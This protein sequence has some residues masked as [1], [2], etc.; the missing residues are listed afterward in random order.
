MICQLYS[1]NSHRISEKIFLTLLLSFI[2][3]IASSQ[4]ST[5]DFTCGI[6][7][8]I[9]NFKNSQPTAYSQ[10]LL[11]Y[12]SLLE[13][14]SKKAREMNQWK[15]NT[16]PCPF[17]ITVIP[18]AFQLFHNNEAI[19]VGHN[20]SLTQLQ[21]VVEQLN[22]DFS[23]Y[24]ALRR[25]VTSAFVNFDADHTCIQFTIGKINRINR[26]ECS[27]WSSGATHTELYKCLPGGF[28]KGSEND[29]NDYLNVY[30]N[31][32][33]QSFLGIAST[34][35]RLYGFANTHDDGV[36]INWDVLI[37]GMY[38][39]SAYNRGGVLTH[40]VAHWLGLPHVN[41][42]YRGGGCENDDGFSDTYPQASQRFYTCRESRVPESCGTADNVFNFMDYSVDCAKLMFT[43]E[44]AVTMQT[45]L[46]EDRFWL[47]ES[48]ARGNYNKDL[49]DLESN[50]LNSSASFFDIQ[51][52]ACIGEINLLGYIEK[53]NSCKNNPTVV[54]AGLNIYSWIKS[55][56]AKQSSLGGIN[57]S[58]TTA[59]HEG[60]FQ[61][62]LCLYY[63]SKKSWNP[64]K[65]KYSEAK[66]IGTLLAS[67]KTCSPPPNDLRE[68][69]ISLNADVNC[70]KNYSLI[71]A[72]YGSYTNYTCHV[73]S[74]LRDVWF[75]AKVNESGNITLEINAV[76]YPGQFPKLEV[77]GPAILSDTK[78]SCLR[79]SINGKIELFNLVPDTKLFMRVS[80]QD[81]IPVNVFN[82]CVSSP[83]LKNDFCE[84]A[85]ILHVANHCSNHSFST[86]GATLSTYPSYK[87][88]C[89]YDKIYQDVWFAMRVPESGRLKMKS[90]KFTGGLNGIIM[91]AYRG[92]C[93]SLV[94][95]ACSSSKG[96][97]SSSEPYSELNLSHLVSGEVIYLRV[98]GENNGD[99]GL[100]NICVSDFLSPPICKIDLIRLE[101][102]SVCDPTRNSYS[103]NLT[104]G[105]SGEAQYV[106]VNNQRFELK[107]NPQEIRLKDLSAN[108]KPLSVVANL[109]SD[110]GD[111]CWKES[112]YLAENLV[113]APTNCYDELLVNDDCFGSIDLHVNNYCKID[114]FS[115]VGATHSS[116]SSDYFACGNSGYRPQDVWFRVTI[117]NSGMLDIYSP[118]FYNEN[119]MI[120]EAYSG[121]CDSL[122]FLQ[123][124]QFGRSS[125]SFIALRNRTKGEQI[126]IR[127]ADHRSNTE[128]FFG[129]CV[130]EPELLGIRAEPLVSQSEKENVKILDH[131][132]ILLYPNPVSNSV[133]VDWS[134]A[135]AHY[136]KARF[137]DILDRISLEFILSSDLKNQTFDL[138]SL[139]EGMYLLILENENGRVAKKFIKKSP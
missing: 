137:I 13:Q 93:D 106:F 15:S 9:Q 63:L 44:Q 75:N 118:L 78:L 27:Y 32:L 8:R 45:I 2:L 18:I 34:I 51:N 42:D 92:S 54:N 14:A 31:E 116:K 120:L 56:G 104:I 134:N 98:A 23:G 135:N 43:A 129:I 49:Y 103:Q 36:S 10:R 87:M 122:S 82:L 12:A 110:K 1:H 66:I 102:Q 22:E 38:P 68:N 58:R 81:S 76:D 69:A 72:T 60:L 126:F 71:N 24:N 73:D 40:E 86:S 77:F 59:V 96:Q 121:D 4:S 47:S 55:Q 99:E 85:I 57:L 70:E 125:G 26:M 29:P 61:T 108:G 65:R 48:Y 53:W 25:N 139:N 109:V 28:G 52:F 100:F 91:E 90:S 50:A 127:V 105:Y 95:V 101:D 114:T 119:N 64:Q 132:S 39:N 111:Q 97:F 79:E 130:I 124:D 35:P 41:G 6:N 89:G 128:G 30:S 83:R 46:E 136:T 84:S 131:Q 33:E 94:S 7:N 74:T 16:D 20:F 117:P 113:Q 133:T 80:A 19:G 88:S 5:G 112:F 11:A 115:N 62:D 67:L 138:C 21:K 123:C 37:P 17:G 107:S 3:S